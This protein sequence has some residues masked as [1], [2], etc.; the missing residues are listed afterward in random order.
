MAYNPCKGVMAV[1]LHVNLDEVGPAEFAGGH[2]VV[3][4]ERGNGERADQARAGL[5]FVGQVRGGGAEVAVR[6]K[7]GAVI[8]IRNGGGVEL[9]PR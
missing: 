4:P 7:I 3:E 9:E 6:K 8:V 1:T 5:A 2:E